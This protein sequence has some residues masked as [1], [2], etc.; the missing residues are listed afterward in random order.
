MSDLRKAAEQALK[1]MADV[2]RLLRY[3]NLYPFVVVDLGKAH[4]ALR[5]ALAEPDEVAAAVEAEREACA[6]VCETIR[7]NGDMA[8]CW[9]EI[10]AAAIRARSK[11]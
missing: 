8:E 6:L 2:E 7:T 9:L 10:A 1:V 4:D 11:P 3:E 5:A